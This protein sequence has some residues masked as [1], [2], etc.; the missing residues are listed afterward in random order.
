MI[1]GKESDKTSV[2][3]M[4]KTPQISFQDIGGLADVKNELKRNDSISNRV[5]RD[6]IGNSDC[7][8]KT[9]FCC[10]VHLV[11]ERQCLLKLSLEKRNP[12]SLA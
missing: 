4:L 12:P 5:C 11:V 9:T 3:E 7:L 1:R 2:S 8:H 10:M 6:P